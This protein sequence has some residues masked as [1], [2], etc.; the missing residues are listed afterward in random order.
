MVEIDKQNLQYNN[1]YASYLGIN[2]VFGQ[3]Q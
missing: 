3:V 2:K 1:I